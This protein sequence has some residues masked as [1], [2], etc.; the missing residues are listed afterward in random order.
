MDDIVMIDFT[1]KPLSVNA[2]RISD[3]IVSNTDCRGFLLA[4]RDSKKIGMDRE[5]FKHYLNELILK[6]YLVK[7]KDDTYNF[8]SKN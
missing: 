4:A 2:Q 3:F 8:Y 6:G 7:L 1:F 5:V